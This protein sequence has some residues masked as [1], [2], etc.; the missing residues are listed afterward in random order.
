MAFNDAEDTQLTKIGKVIIDADGIRIEGFDTSG[1]QS[2]RE[3]AILATCW[4]LGQLQ[5]EM[6]A[7]MQR[8]GGNGRL[9]M[10]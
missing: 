6:M 8:P 10:D 3:T 2:C 9:S 4:A 1:R 7:T 5:A